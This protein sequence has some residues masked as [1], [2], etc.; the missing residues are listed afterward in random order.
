MTT[1]TEIVAFMN[2]YPGQWMDMDQLVRDTG[3]PRADAVK[4]IREM[5]TEGLIRFNRNWG[6]DA[7]FKLI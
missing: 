2:R 7:P 6:T 3:I 5:A 1:R 4:E